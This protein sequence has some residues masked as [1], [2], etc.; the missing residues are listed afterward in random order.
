MERK[1]FILYV[2]VLRSIF[3]VLD[4]ENLGLL[5]KHITEY[6]ETGESIAPDK[7]SPAFVLAFE[8]V[9]NHIDNNT[10]SY[11]KIREKRKDAARKRWDN[12]KQSDA[13]NANDANG[14]KSIQVHTN[15]ANDANGCLN[16]NVNVNV[17]ENVNVNVSTKVDDNIK[18]KAFKSNKFDAT[19]FVEFFNAEMERAKALIPR[20]Q[21]VSEKRKTMVLARIREY[22]KESL[23]TVVQKAAASNFL[24]GRN[25][26]AF[27]ASFDWLIKP[28]N[29]PKVLEGNYDNV[30]PNGKPAATEP[31]GELM[32]NVGKERQQREKENEQRIRSLYEAAQQGDERAKG[33][34][35]EMRK[36]G[37]LKQYGLK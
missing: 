30:T 23:V 24:N 20:I 29:Y 7:F 32:Q 17:N 31:I 5:I 16:D 10:E 11:E 12:P 28:T 15:D 4:N 25:Q 36:N 27:I 2:D 3:K 22:G 14:C 21:S 9:K 19:R 18:A 13:N 34:V 1:S 8:I 6:A 35:D 37:V 33:I 26:R